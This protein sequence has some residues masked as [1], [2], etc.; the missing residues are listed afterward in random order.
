MRIAR[1]VHFTGMQWDFQETGYLEKN[2]QQVFRKIF[3]EQEVFW[4]TW[5]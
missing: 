1:K 4:T 2:G 5:E 3:N